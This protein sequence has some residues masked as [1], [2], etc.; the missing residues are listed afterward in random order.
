[1]REAIVRDDLSIPASD[2]FIAAF[3]CDVEFDEQT[4]TE[5]YTFVDELDQTLKMWIGTAD[6]T[7]SL[8]VVKNETESVRVYDECLSCIRL[9]EDRKMILIILGKDSCT[10]KLEIAVWPRI[11]ASFTRMR[12]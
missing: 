2:D 12:C 10:Q 11:T 5:L 9:D 7:F 6:R 1:M 8:S 4:Y 3:G